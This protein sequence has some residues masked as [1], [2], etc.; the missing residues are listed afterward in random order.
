MTA[1]D[2]FDHIDQLL[3]ILGSRNRGTLTLE[4]GSRARIVGPGRD[5]QDVSGRVLSRQEILAMVGPIVPEHARRQL[6]RE[7]SVSFDYACPAVGPFKLTMARD[8]ERLIVTIVSEHPAA[9]APE[10]AAP[11]PSV[12]AAAPAP[13]PVQPAAATAT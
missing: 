1:A 6:P 12:V 3:K 4:A 8:S 2:G 11:A 5:S 13:T 10:P 9:G 7:P